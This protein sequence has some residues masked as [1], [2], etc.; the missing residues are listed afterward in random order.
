MKISSKS[1]A[2]IDSCNKIRKYISKTK[3]T[4]KGIKNTDAIYE[5]AKILGDSSITINTPVNFRKIWLLRQ[6]KNNEL[7]K[8]LISKEDSQILSKNRR[9]IKPK[10]S[11]KPTLQAVKHI[12]KLTWAQEY[13][14]FLRSTYWKKLR[15]VVI[16][17]DKRWCVIC[18]RSDKLHV[19]HLTYEHHLS[20]HEHLE[21]LITLCED[22]HNKEH[23]RLREL[24]KSNQND[25]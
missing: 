14:L 23:E 1:K 3:G 11:K 7:E 13:K 12:K 17:R 4:C 6:V 24:K 16:S 15:Q 22:C 2:V 18:K 8:L 19:H 10:P 21:D 9:L 25:I 5:F 20:E